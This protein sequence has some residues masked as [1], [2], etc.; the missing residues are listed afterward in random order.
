MES[1]LCKNKEVFRISKSSAVIWVL[2][3]DILLSLKYKGDNYGGR[4]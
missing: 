2:C 1:I 4:I 3:K